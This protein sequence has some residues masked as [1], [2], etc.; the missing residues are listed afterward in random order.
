MSPEDFLR[1][2]LGTITLLLVL[3]VVFVQSGRI[4]DDTQF[5]AIVVSLFVVTILAAD[6][7]Q[8]AG[9]S[10]HFFQSALES[11]KALKV[12]FRVRAANMYEGFEENVSSLQALPWTLYDTL[13]PSLE[14]LA[15]VIRGDA[16]SV[17]QDTKDF[18]AKDYETKDDAD[19]LGLDG[20]VDVKK[21]DAMKLDYKQIVVLLCRMKGMAPAYHD[22][23]VN[24]LGG[25]APLPIPAAMPVASQVRGAPP[26]PPST[27]PAN[28]HATV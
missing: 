15:G 17:E 10:L 3:Y 18:N 24:A 2:V 8:S 7:C 16:G 22:Y 25:C 19:L 11:L 23:L 26:K 1:G 28:S 21:F 6:N 5:L 13:V 14:Q 27:T 9:P 4:P 12:V 20:K